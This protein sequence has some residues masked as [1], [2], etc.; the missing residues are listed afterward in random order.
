MSLMKGKNNCSKKVFLPLVDGSPFWTR[1]KAL[2]RDQGEV[3]TVISEPEGGGGELD[4]SA[5]T[6]NDLGITSER[7][8]KSQRLDR[9]LLIPNISSLQDQIKLRAH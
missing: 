2:R 1:E 9:V 5:R 7:K 8:K 4:C 3:V 6:R